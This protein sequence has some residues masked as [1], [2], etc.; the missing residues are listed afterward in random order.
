M[1]YKI[2]LI[3]EFSKPWNNGWYYKA[4]FEK[5]G[6]IIMPFDPESDSERRIFELVKEDRPD[7]VLHT[8]DEFPAEVFHELKKQVKVIMWYPDPVIPE[9]LP[10]YVKACDVF[11]TMSVI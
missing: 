5:N 8:K 3:T 11:F 7:F 1:P 9:W 10:P 4:G 2:I 6:H